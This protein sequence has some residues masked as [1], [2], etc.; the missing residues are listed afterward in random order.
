MK[1]LMTIEEKKKVLGLMCKNNL[2]KQEWEGILKNSR[3]LK[4][5]FIANEEWRC[6]MDLVKRKFTTG[7]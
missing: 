7:S 5:V 4:K 3:G 2:L 6:I 1:T